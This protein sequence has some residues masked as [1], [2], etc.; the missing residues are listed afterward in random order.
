MCQNN[1]AA[2]GS[3]IASGPIKRL[4]DIET[5]KKLLADKPREYAL[6][7]IGIN[8]GFRASDLLALQVGNVRDILADPDDGDTVR[9]K[10]ELKMRRISGNKAVKEAVERLLASRSY[11]DSDLLFQGKR[12]AMTTSWLR[13]LVRGWCEA[14]NLRGHYGSHTLRKTWGYHQRV[15][16]GVDIPTLM[17]CFNQSTQKQTLDY[18]CIQPE[19]IRSVYANVL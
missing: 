16:F 18:L 12:G 14:I 15:T 9:E 6:F 3:K 5:I 7:V 11:K 17:V 1:H 2:P 19:E 8:T 10:K 13:R 4:K